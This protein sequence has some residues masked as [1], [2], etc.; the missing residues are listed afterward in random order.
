MIKMGPMRE[1]DR[2]RYTVGPLMT[3]RVCITGWGVHSLS[4]RFRLRPVAE[5]AAKGR[6]SSSIYIACHVKCAIQINLT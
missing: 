4:H 2:D 3:L 1:R 6:G 5:A